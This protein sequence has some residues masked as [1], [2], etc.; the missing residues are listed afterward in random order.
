MVRMVLSN[1]LIQTFLKVAPGNRETVALSK[2]GWLMNDFDLVIVDLP[3]SGHAVTM[4]EAPHTMVGLFSSGPIRSEGLNA[5]QMLKAD[6]THLILVSLP[7]EMVINATIE[8]FQK[9][10]EVLPDLSINGVILNRSDEVSFSEKEKGLLDLLSR[11]NKDSSQ[12]VEELLWAGRWIT[13]RGEAS[14]KAQERLEKELSTT[15]C[16][17][18]RLSQNGGA[19]R[20]VSYMVEQLQQGDL[21]EGLL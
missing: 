12:E 17:L 10:Q 16:R 11:E 14:N 19:K 9:L 1:S 4:L 5:L 7:E 21:T 15:V 8:T 2:I 13:Q 18:P 3:A 6:T 20:L